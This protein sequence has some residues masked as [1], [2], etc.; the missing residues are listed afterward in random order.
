MPA[1][2]TVS[3]VESDPDAG[4]PLVFHPDKAFDVIICLRFSER[5]TRHRLQAL[6]PKALR[7]SAIE[8]KTAYRSDRWERYLLAGNTDRQFVKRLDCK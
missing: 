7:L 4:R 6:P 8:I 1:A 5:M 3:Y 2:V